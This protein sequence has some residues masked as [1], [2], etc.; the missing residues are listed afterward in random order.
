MHHNS[1]NVFITF[2]TGLFKY[3]YQNVTASHFRGM[4]V[5]M[6]YAS[7]AQSLC[8]HNNRCLLDFFIDYNN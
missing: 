8:V 5:C 2:V 3:W 4:R 1:L 7:L 6:S